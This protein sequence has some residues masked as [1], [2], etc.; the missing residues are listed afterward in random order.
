LNARNLPSL[1]F[2]AKLLTTVGLGQRLNV[3]SFTFGEISVVQ[4]TLQQTLLVTPLGMTQGQP[5]GQAC[6]A[7]TLRCFGCP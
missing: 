7:R 6:T 5:D 4:V 1:A 3:D 2:A